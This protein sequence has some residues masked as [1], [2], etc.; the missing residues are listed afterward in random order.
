VASLGFPESGKQGLFRDFWHPVAWSSELGPA[1]LSTVLLGERLVV[2]RG[3]SGPVAA[4]DRCPHRGTALSLG[5]V[6]AE[7]CLSCPYHGWRF[8][9]EGRCV[10]VPQLRAGMPIPARAQVP[11]HRC[12]ERYGM[13]WACLGMPRA[14]VPAFPEWD[15]PSFRHVACER[16]RWKTSPERMVENFTDFG[17]LGYLHD[18]LLGTRDDLVVPD[19][20]VRREG[21]SLLYEMTMEVPNP[22]GLFAVADLDSARGT[23]RN[24][25]V[26]SLPYTIHLVSEYVARGG[27]RVLFFAVQPHGDGT[28]SGYCYQSRDFDLGGA[29]EP[30]AR[31]QALLAEQDRVVVES[32]E[33]LEVP[34]QLGAELHLPF[35]KVA[36]AYR[37]A[38]S[39]LF[40]PDRQDEAE[41]GAALAAAGGGGTCS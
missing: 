29:D 3:P 21:L 1:P 26:L 30:Y 31:F 7:G 16:Y 36:V 4:P 9:P 17:H 34:N 10:E 15:D 37:R 12:T 6:D 13:V 35:D 33:P 14:S 11:V 8:D 32:Q 23:Q 22:K 41:A 28:C 2:W 18:G 27:R 40:G 5:S 25:Y 20:R 24:S 19:H 38:M 39:E